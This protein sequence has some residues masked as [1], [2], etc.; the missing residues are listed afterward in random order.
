MR[1]GGWY[2][3]Y[4]FVGDM[5]EVRISNVV[6]S[7]DWVKLEYENQKPLQTLVGGIVPAGSDF[8]VSPASVTMNE[9]TGTTLTA[10]A[11]G[12]QKTYW[13]YK[14]NAQETLLATDQLTLN[15]TAPR[16]S[17]NDS[18]V[19][20]FKAVFA[21]GTQTIDVP[22]T[23]LDT[24]PDPAFTLVPSTTQWDGRQTMTVTANI[25]NLAAMQAAGFGH[26]DVHNLTAGVVALHVG[27][28]C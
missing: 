20:Q 10:Q 23:V 16:L 26:V 9:S 2:N 14:K 15:Y 11:G 7:A 4:R 6:R 8:S 12:A 27:I 21:G 28:R 24:V 19:I 3:G 5:D 17:A 18:A 1:L 25:T 22:L 13:I